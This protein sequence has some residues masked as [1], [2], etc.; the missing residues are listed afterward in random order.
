[1]HSLIKLIYRSK[2]EGVSKRDITIKSG[3]LGHKKRG[4]KEG[5]SFMYKPSP[6]KKKK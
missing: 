2:R 6:L 4:K 3:G 1:M 5:S